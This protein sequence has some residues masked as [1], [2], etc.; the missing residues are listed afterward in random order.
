MT[1]T[2]PKKPYYEH[3]GI[4]IYHG[5]CREILP[6]LSWAGLVLTDPPYKFEPSGGG[7]FFEASG[8]RTTLAELDALSCC[9]FDV[10]AFLSILDPIH[11]VAFCNKALLPGYLGFADQH[12]IL[13]DVHVMHKNN[14]VPAKGSSFLPEVEYIVVLRTPRSYFDNSQ[15]FDWYRK[16]HYVHRLKSAH[17]QHPAEK[18]VSVLKKYIGILCPPYGTVV[19]PYMGS[20]QTLIAARSM[21]R[22]AIGIEIEE[23]YC[24]IAAKRLSQA[25]LQF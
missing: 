14:P 6:Q 9:D 20:G 25:V 23:R 11:L 15:Q 24:E 3:A 12:G 10:A 7:I 21:D 1:E 17:K 13:F 2:G 22:R 19:D 16:V 4:T 8:W 5:D 18:P